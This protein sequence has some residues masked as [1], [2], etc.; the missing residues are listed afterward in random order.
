MA[1][2]ISHLCGRLVVMYTLCKFCI[3]PF[4][5]SLACKLTNASMTS[6]KAFNSSPVT[7]VKVK[8]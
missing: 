3:T 5:C 2:Y 8:L 1:C 4:A 7:T 6:V